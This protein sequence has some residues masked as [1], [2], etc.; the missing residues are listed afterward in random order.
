MFDPVQLLPNNSLKGNIV[1]EFFVVLFFCN[2]EKFW[3]PSES[4][5]GQF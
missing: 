1:R 2:K 4:S 3:G 5:D